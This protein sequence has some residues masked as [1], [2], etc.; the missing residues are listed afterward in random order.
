MGFWGCLVCVFLVAWILYKADPEN[1]FWTGSQQSNF[2]MY[3]S[4]MQLALKSLMFV[5]GVLSGNTPFTDLSV[6]PIPSYVLEYGQYLPR[7]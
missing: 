4:T 3:L 2:S 5:S 6:T 7:T 1:L